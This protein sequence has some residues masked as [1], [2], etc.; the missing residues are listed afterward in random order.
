MK[1]TSA[2]GEHRIAI[3]SEDIPTSENEQSLVNQCS[4]LE[5]KN[6][7]AGYQTPYFFYSM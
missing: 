4:L 5:K 3:Y 7:M 2:A 6:N 1:I